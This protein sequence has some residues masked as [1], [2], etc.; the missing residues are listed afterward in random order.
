MT[1]YRFVSGQSDVGATTDSQPAYR[2]PPPPRIDSISGTNIFINI[3]RSTVPYLL[4]HP[5]DILLAKAFKINLH[6][7]SFSSD[8]KRSRLERR[9]RL[10]KNGYSIHL[11]QRRLVA[12]CCYSSFASFHSPCLH[13]Q[14]TFSSVVT[15]AAVVQRSR[16]GPRYPA[17]DMNLAC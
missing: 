14:E 1:N 10:L 7:P 5:C 17:Y 16:F 3:A 11:H 6:S 2:K 9:S 13:C 12:P 8:V 15:I 4:R